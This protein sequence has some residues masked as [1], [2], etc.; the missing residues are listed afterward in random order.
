MDMN[1]WNCESRVD[2]GPGPYVANVGCMAVN[3]VH[4]R[5][6]LWTGGNA[7]MTRVSI[8]VCSDVGAESHGYGYEGR[9][10]GEDGYSDKSWKRR[11]RV[12]SSW[13]MA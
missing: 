6:T 9:L 10:S 3:S 13:Y 1:N 11:Y 7:Q 2:N 12:C 8:P 4:F 5:H